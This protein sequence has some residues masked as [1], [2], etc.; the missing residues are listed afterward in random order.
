MVML[1]LVMSGYMRLSQVR[2]SYDRLFQVMT[3]KVRLG[4]VRPGYLSLFQVRSY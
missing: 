1:I 2:S 3:R 4:Q